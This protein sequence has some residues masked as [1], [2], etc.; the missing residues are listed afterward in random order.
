MSNIIVGP[1]IQFTTK[2]GPNRPAA[3]WREV[4][5][6]IFGGLM[7]SFGEIIEDFGD[8]LRNFGD[9]GSL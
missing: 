9:I 8:F 6:L 3:E 4:E 7:M 2:F 5:N 1:M